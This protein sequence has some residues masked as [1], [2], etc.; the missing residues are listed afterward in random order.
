MKAAPVNPNTVTSFCVPGFSDVPCCSSKTSTRSCLMGCVGEQRAAWLLSMLRASSWTS[1]VGW[2]GF[3]PTG[4]AGRPGDTHAGSMS[5]LL[6]HQ[7]PFCLDFSL[8]EGKEGL[9]VKTR[10]RLTEIVRMCFFEAGRSIA[11]KCA[12]F[13]A[14]CIR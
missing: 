3:S 2:L 6:Q 12:R 8:R 10:M 14:L 5:A 4:P 9:L 7:N 13:L 11:H 1:C